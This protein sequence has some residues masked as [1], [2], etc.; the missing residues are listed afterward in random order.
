MDVLK[1]NMLY[2]SGF[3]VYDRLHVQ[4]WKCNEECM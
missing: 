4:L 3:Y 2:N 1:V